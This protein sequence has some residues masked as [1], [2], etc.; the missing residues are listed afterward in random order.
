MISNNVASSSSL[1]FYKQKVPVH[2][3]SGEQ[4]LTAIILQQLLE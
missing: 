3:L 4:K 2:L 1:N